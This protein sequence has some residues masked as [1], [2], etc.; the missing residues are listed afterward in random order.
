[1]RSQPIQTENVSV[2]VNVNANVSVSVS[3][4]AQVSLQL[5]SLQ[6]LHEIVLMMFHERAA[7]KLF[8]CHYQRQFNPRLALTI[9]QL[10]SRLVIPV[11]GSWFTAHIHALNP[12]L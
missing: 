11:H 2:S 4:S 1:M 6:V 5:S 10:S 3:A 9:C 7:L 12:E 8:S